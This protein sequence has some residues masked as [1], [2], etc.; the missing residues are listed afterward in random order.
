MRE[1]SVKDR[2]AP[3]RKGPLSPAVC[4]MVPF[5]LAGGAARAEA[6]GYF[7]PPGQP[8]ERKTP[9]VGLTGQGS[10]VDAT[11][12]AGQAAA[13]ANSRI[14]AEQ[15]YVTALRPVLKPD[16]GAHDFSQAGPFTVE[17]SDTGPSL[18]E[19]GRTVTFAY[20]VKGVK[21]MDLTVNTFAG[22]RDT[23]TGSNVGSAALT[24]GVRFKW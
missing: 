9:G 22:H 15:Y 7:M 12:S 8:G 13:A 21:G 3:V 19:H 11:K 2:F 6:G 20:P 5:L 17:Y 10:A 18:S 23:N 4:L 14:A 1:R 16:F 24:A